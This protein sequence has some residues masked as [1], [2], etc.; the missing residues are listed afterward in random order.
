MLGSNLSFLLLLP[1]VVIFW[2]IVRLMRGMV[3]NNF[4]VFRSSFYLFLL[5]FLG[6][7]FL[8]FIGR[9]AT[10]SLAFETD[11]VTVFLVSSIALGVGSLLGVLFYT[12]NGFIPTFFTR[13]NLFLAVFSVIVGV[14]VTYKTSTFVEQEIPATGRMV[15]VGR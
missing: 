8:I 4:H 3:K 9:N 11:L 2:G 15:E 13:L 7:S 5:G 6:V 14:A 10:S 1:L 12:F